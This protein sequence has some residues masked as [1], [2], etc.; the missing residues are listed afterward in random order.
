[1]KSNET[2]L[3]QDELREEL[4]VARRRVEE[5]E[6]TLQARSDKECELS[7]PE[8]ELTERVKELNCLLSISRLRN[9]PGTSTQV[10]LRGIVDLIPPA[11]QFPESTCARISLP[12]Y[13]CR[14]ESYQETRWRLSHDVYVQE[15][16]VGTL[17]VCYLDEKP[18]RDIGPFLFE[19]RNLLEAIAERIGRVIAR[20]K[21]E[22]KALEQ[23]RQMVRLDKMV[24]LGTLVSGVA[25]EIN[26]PNNFVML[27]APVL[28]DA[29]TSIMP[30][31]D[32]TR[33][34]RGDF[35]VAGL[36]YSEMREAIPS[37]LSGILEGARRISAIVQSLKEFARSDTPGFQELVDMNGVIQ[38]A[39]MLVGNL[40][41][42]RTLNFSVELQDDLPSIKGNAQR[43]EQVVINLVQNAYESLMDTSGSICVTTAS[44]GHNVLV[45]VS[46]DGCGIPATQI[47]HITDPFYT[48]KRDV[49][50]TGLG[51][52]VSHGIV[53]EHEGTMSFES[54]EEEGTTV[55]IAFP[56]WGEGETPEEVSA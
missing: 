23:Q 24:A 7:E 34:A 9:A 40:V 36:P 15:E 13:D 22:A 56:V 2:N 12:D 50:G 31:L 39:L 44:R 10:M 21:A 32:E 47:P 29:F 48:N 16:R 52:S 42:R 55:T 45:T 28:D 41:K 37:L 35:L 54:K 43:L 1:M 6:R 30:I 27:N 49:G 19:E 20:E 33:E 11:W 53:K 26:N 3:V 18:P 14:T 25:H 46:D 17:H 51:L 5:L 4:S 8:R 38:S